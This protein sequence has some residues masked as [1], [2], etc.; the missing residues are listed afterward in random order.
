MMY[1]VYNVTKEQA[2]SKPMNHAE[3]TVEFYNV[4]AYG[5]YNYGDN[6]VIKPLKE[7]K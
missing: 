5:S 6:I 7:G 3:V 1:V 2:M 4:K